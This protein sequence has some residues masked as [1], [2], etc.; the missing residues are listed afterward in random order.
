M[1]RATRTHDTH[2]L[3]RVHT[4]AHTHAHRFLIPSHMLECI[5]RIMHILA[6]IHMHIPDTQMH[7][8]IPAHTCTYRTTA[9][10]YSCTH[11]YTHEHSRH[12][13][14]ML[15][16]CAYT[17]PYLHTCSGQAHAHTHT[18][19]HAHT[20]TRTHTC[21]HMHTHTHTHTHIRIP[22]WQAQHD[23]RA[24]CEHSV[25]HHAHV[26]PPGHRVPPAVQGSPR[27]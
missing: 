11:A 9:D 18:H 21:T 5:C 26:Q 1:H 16:T 23:A 14:R 20:H 4:H 19:T 6:S 15:N 3:A 24:V 17:Y 12:M 7:M 8:H 13:M 10:T 27:L 2:N 22:I 25:A